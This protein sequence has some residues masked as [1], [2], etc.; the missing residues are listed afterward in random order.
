M[1]WLIK[2]LSCRWLGHK[3]GK[4]EAFSEGGLV[5]FRC[6]RCGATWTRKERKAKATS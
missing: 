2:N 3:R 4:R 5:M 6:P 1:N